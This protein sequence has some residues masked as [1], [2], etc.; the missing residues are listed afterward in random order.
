[1]GDAAAGRLDGPTTKRDAPRP[2]PPLFDLGVPPRDFVASRILLPTTATVHKLG[3]DFNGDGNVDN[4]LGSILGAL[5]NIS[6]S[7]N[8][9]KTMDNAVASGITLILLRLQAPDYVNTPA[10]AG[11]TWVGQSQ[12]CTKSCFGG[13]HTFPTVPDTKSSLTG[14]ITAGQIYL[15]PAKMH[16]RLF[17]GAGKV[18]DLTLRQASL[19][20]N[21][22]AGIK[23]GVLAGA[24]DQ[25]DLKTQLI[26]AVAQLLN[27]VLND[28]TTD[29][30][31]RDTI[32]TLFDADKD[33]KV[34]IAEVA[35]NSIIKT[36][37][38][39]DVDV[40]G[41]GVNEISLGLGFEAVTARI[42]P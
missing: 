2:P 36:F 29:K 28:P 8:L 21:L 19:R 16:F 7:L 12:P 40:D 37:L 13:N 23:N 25:K 38:S 3:A 42:Q 14:R 6:G 27:N 31:T 30:Q 11:W 18:M 35:Q 5:S 22:G 9:Q 24:I 17:I 1:V 15:G 32:A 10:A 20:G 39:G 26:P 41:D 33:G 4:A 34:S